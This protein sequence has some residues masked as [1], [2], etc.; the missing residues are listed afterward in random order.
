MKLIRRSWQPEPP[1]TWVTFVPS[2]RQP[3]LVSDLACRLAD[4]L[5]L[6]CQD[7]VVKVRNTR[8]QKVL[9]NG[10]QQFRIEALLDGGTVETAGGAFQLDAA[11]GSGTLFD[12]A[13]VG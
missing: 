9:L 8:P 4:A 5:E 3:G 6:P 13:A 10:Q 1:P 2:L 11:P 12:I 7:V